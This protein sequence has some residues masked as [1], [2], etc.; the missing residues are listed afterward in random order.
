[1]TDPTDWATSS[2]GKYKYC[3]F[4]HNA[5]KNDVNVVGNPFYPASGAA[6][7]P[8]SVY[9]ELT[10]LATLY[11]FATLAR[12]TYE[13]YPPTNWRMTGSTVGV[14][15]PLFTGEYYARIEPMS[16]RMF[17]CDLHEYP[18]G[19]LSD[20]ANTNQL[21][22]ANM[23]GLNVQPQMHEPDRVDYDDSARGSEIFEKLFEDRRIAI[24][25]GLKA[26]KF[27]WRPATRFDHWYKKFDLDKINDAQNVASNRD[28]D[29][30]VGGLWLGIDW[31]HFHVQGGE[32]GSSETIFHLPF[33]LKVKF[34]F[35]VTGRT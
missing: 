12:V 15:D 17:G 20:N 29:Q 13:V 26:K 10:R 14:N 25:S 24:F 28:D 27:V 34:A 21:A 30:R 11:R 5:A 8:I 19:P 35:E 31:S 16:I 7:A 23:L 3:T 32:G 4:G 6:Y 9:E 1:M 22:V 2:D 18:Q 33:V